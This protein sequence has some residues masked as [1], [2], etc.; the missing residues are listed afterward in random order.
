MFHLNPIGPFYYHELLLPS[1]ILSGKGI[2]EFAKLLKSKIG[3]KHTILYS[4]LFTFIIFHTTN[5]SQKRFYS[6]YKYINIVKQPIQELKNLKLQNSIV[7]L[8]RSDP[9]IHHYLMNS[10]NLKNTL[11]VLDRGHKNNIK[12]SSYYPDH[13][14]YLLNIDYKH[15]G[16]IQVSYNLRDYNKVKHFY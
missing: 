3:N 7:F 8:Q 10:F 13:K 12:F 1:L 2:S 5:Y 11:I 4:I 16:I 6:I 15:N 9:P 14:T